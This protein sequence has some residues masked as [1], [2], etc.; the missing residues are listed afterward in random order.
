MAKNQIRIG[1]SGF[2][3]PEWKGS[4]YP[5]DLP[6]KQYLSYYA[7]HFSTTEINN[8]FYRIPSTKTT[9]QW[10]SEV[11]KNF[12]FT[13]KLNQK[14]THVKRLKN[15][16][17]ELKWFLEGAAGLREKLG[18]ILVQLPPYFRKDA[19]CLE[20]FLALCSAEARL[21]FEFRHESWFEQEIYD[22]LQKYHS[23]WAVVESEDREAIREVT[24]NFIYMRLRKGDYSKKELGKWAKWIGS[25]SVD[26]YCYLKHDEKAP[27]LAKQ[28]MEA[29]QG[30][31]KT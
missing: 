9:A 26:V 29:V 8:T 10:Y 28:L 18:T 20:E 23:A 19:A 12:S 24:A 22:L 31:K 27:L 4:F 5:Q 30:T 7:R 11:P 25:Q 21:A 13:L 14:I 6:S 15:V 2:S 3:Y 17:E 1:T 16:G